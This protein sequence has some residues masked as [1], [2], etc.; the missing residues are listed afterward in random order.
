MS[1][2]RPKKLKLK[3][4]DSSQ[5][6]SLDLGNDQMDYKTSAISKHHQRYAKLSI[7]E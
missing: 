7:K 5:G 1:T 2:D 3:S 6:G 4:V